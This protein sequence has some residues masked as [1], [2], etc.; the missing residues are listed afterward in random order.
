MIPLK[1][2]VRTAGVPVVT[3]ALILAAAFSWFALQGGVIGRPAGLAH[4]ARRHGVVP[5]RLAH[6]ARAAPAS[7]RATAPWLTPLTGALLSA[8][9]VPLAVNLLFLWNFGPCVETA[10]GRLRFAL[11]VPLAALAAAAPLALLEPGSN[12]PLIG[13]APVVAGVVGAAFAL[14]PR[15]KVVG[16]SLI[17][18]VATT[19]E[20][21]GAVMLAL[22]AGAQGAFA[23]LDL[24]DPLGGGGALAWVAYA[25]GLIA[26]LLLARPLARSRRGAS[27]APAL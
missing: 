7:D 6:P 16:L 18:I 21:P 3:V 4:D 19:L 26:G 17:P 24:T 25:G 2:N 15:L 20:I 12:A 13:A 23:A 5:A 10:L 27:P 22:W 14:H 9:I 1:V 8:S 11:L